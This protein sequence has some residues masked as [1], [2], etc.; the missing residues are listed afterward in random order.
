MINGFRG[1]TR[2]KFMPDPIFKYFPR[3]EHRVTSLNLT[4]QQSL[5]A[6]VIYPVYTNS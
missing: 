6:K 3:L 5:S 2:Q 1:Y 4:S